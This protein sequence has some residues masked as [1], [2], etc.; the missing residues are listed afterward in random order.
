MPI[1][2][3]PQN[4]RTLSYGALL[5]ESLR[6]YYS[7]N[8][9]GVLNTLFKFCAACIAPL[10]GPFDD[11]DAERQLAWLVAQCAWETGQLTNVLNFIY[12]PVDMGIFITQSASLQVSLPEFSYT[13]TVAVPEFGFTTTISVQ[14]FNQPSPHTVLTFNVPT[15]LAGQLSAITATIAQV[16]LA[17]IDYIIVLY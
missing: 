17:G 12:D 11:Y 1:G 15:A 10:Q 14:E 5:Y 7:V 3:G 8:R 16:A 6:N 9:F 4:F 13:S 2:Q